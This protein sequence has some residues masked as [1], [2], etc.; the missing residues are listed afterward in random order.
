MILELKV[1]STPDDAITQI[2]DKDYALR[3]RGKPGGKQIYTGRILAVGISYSKK[4]KKH[5]CKVEVL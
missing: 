4:T 3:F 1:G 2:K 5:S